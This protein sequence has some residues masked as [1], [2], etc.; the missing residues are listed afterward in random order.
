MELVLC[1]LDWLHKICQEQEDMS[2][3]SYNSL[4]R[5]VTNMYNKKKE[6]SNINNSGLEKPMVII[7]NYPAKSRVISP[8]T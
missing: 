3:K 6:S 4:F 1:H 7:N 5:A 8:D 2:C